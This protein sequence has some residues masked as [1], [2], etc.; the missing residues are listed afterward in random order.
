MPRIA[1]EIFYSSFVF[2]IRH[3]IIAGQILNCE[4]IDLNN[5]MTNSRPTSYEFF[6]LLFKIELFAF[7]RHLSFLVRH[8]VIFWQAFKL[9]IL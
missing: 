1:A 3:S 6:V 8:S 9:P 2:F 5:R 7:V 4:H